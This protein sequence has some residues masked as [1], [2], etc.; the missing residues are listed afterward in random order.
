MVGTSFHG[1]ES[2][3]RSSEARPRGESA[4]QQ[5]CAASADE[6]GRALE[7]KRKCWERGG[8]SR[9]V[10][11]P[12]VPERTWE[13]KSEGPARGKVEIRSRGDKRSGVDG[14]ASGGEIRGG[15]GRSDG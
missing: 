6:I 8:E 11:R 14:D 4:G 1:R 15:C 9:A 3:R 13:G 2:W 5:R 12:G 7:G 10:P